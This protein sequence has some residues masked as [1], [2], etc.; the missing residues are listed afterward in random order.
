RDVDE[1]R[2]IAPSQDPRL[3]EI[4]IPRALYPDI[5]PEFSRPVPPHMLPSR[6]RRLSGAPASIV[7]RGCS[8]LQQLPPQHQEANVYPHPA[9]QT[10]VQTVGDAL[11]P[12]RHHQQQQQQQTQA[13]SY[14]SLIPGDCN[15]AL[16]SNRVNSAH[17]I[18]ATSLLPNERKT[19]ASPTS[20]SQ[21]A[22]NTTLPSHVP[23]PQACPNSTQVLAQVQ[24]PA[25]Y[26][27][28]SNP[29]VSLDNSTATPP[30]S[31]LLMQSSGHSNESSSLRRRTLQDSLRES[32][33]D[34][35]STTRDSFPDRYSTMRDSSA[36]SQETV[37]V[38]LP[39]ISELLKSIDRHDPPL[40]SAPPKH[41]LLHKQ[42]IKTSEIDSDY[43]AVLARAKP[44]GYYLGEDQLASA[45]ANKVPGY[46]F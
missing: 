3:C 43:L 44:G 28:F 30:P 34:R 39:P 20:I 2:L 4:S 7:V 9:V 40:H 21:Q 14:H 1:G 22:P 26:R 13:T 18:Q 24:A 16:Q 38:Q 41:S 25:S 5:L 6:K 46:P 32:S 35:Y 37:R 17:T 23:N 12:V 10:A 8:S 31:L 11:S 15:A 45:V 29:T 27:S 36:S 33:P 42:N 19:V